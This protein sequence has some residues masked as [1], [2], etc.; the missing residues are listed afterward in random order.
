MITSAAYSNFSAYRYSLPVIVFVFSVC[1][2]VF[3]RPTAL[4]CYRADGPVDYQAFYRPV[5]VNLL[6]GYGLVDSRGKPALRY[7]PGYPLILAGVFKVADA[8]HISER[9]VAGALILACAGL[10]SVF[11]FL[12]ARALWGLPAALL[13]PAGF[14]TYPPFLWL[15]LQPHVELPFIAVLYA[16]LWIFFLAWRRE[17]ARMDLCLVSGILLGAAT[18]IKPIAFGVPLVLAGM[19]WRIRPEPA[20]GFRL[21][22]PSLLLTGSL[23]VII[24]WEVWVYLR[25]GKI[26]FLS[27]GGL[28]SLLDGLTFGVNLKGY[29]QGLRLPE[30]VT[31]LMLHF[32]GIRDQITGFSS[33]I[34]AVLERLGNEPL[35]VIKLFLLKASRAWFGT[36][37]QRFE[38]LLLVIQALYVIG[39]LAASKRSLGQ[40]STKTGVTL[41]IWAICLYFWLMTLLVL[42]ILRY[43]LPALGLFFILAPAL[44]KRSRQ[45][46]HPEP[47]KS[48]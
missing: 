30:D 9:H 43:L 11:I 3:F 37:S 31:A 17:R 1:A 15:T 38:T 6:D 34:Q 14:L 23:A 46:L 16:G 29:R 8:L 19:L 22:C 33:V 18:L 42:P 28:P 45:S 12:M 7:P 25:T 5:A 39:F 20:R 13:A 24:P 41:G 4:A 32:Q 44:P 47:E 48:G 21:T 40:D 2:I 26:I 36:D 35:A 10:S 27:T